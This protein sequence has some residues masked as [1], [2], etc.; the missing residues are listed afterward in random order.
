[1]DNLLARHNGAPSQDHPII[2]LEPDINSG[3]RPAPVAFTVATE[4]SYL[5]TD[6]GTGGGAV[7]F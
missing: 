1:M 7:S 3:D 6:P 5:L 2:I 4:L